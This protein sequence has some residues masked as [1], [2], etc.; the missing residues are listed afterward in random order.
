MNAFWTQT[1]CRSL[2]VDPSRFVFGLFPGTCRS[3]ALTV[4]KNQP[5]AAAPPLAHITTRPA[6]LS[7]LQARIVPAKT[8]FFLFSR[9]APTSLPHPFRVLVV[10]AVVEPKRNLT[11]QTK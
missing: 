5:F 2:C 9:Q 4:A 10:H 1:G 8:I 3:D 11:K 7:P 6:F